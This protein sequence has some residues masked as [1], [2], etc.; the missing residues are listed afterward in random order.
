M[1]N[2][3]HGY[4]VAVKGSN[5]WTCLVG[6]SWTAGFDDPEF[7]NPKGRGPGCLN[8]PAVQTVLPQYV[9]RTAWALAGNT[10][11]EMAK[12]AQAAY[13][14]HHFTDPAPGSF[15]FMLSKQ[16][17]LLGADGPWHPHVMPFIAYNQSAIWAAGWEGSPVNLPSGATTIAGTYMRPYEPIPIAIP[18]LRWSDG[19][20]GPP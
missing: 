3:V 14:S 1:R 10:R 2:S 13:A 18:V 5:G 9:E 11:E 17:Y 15:A 6:R 7:W 12:K 4:D 8:P 19:S 16:G 20:P